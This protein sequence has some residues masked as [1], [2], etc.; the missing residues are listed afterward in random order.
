MREFPVIDISH[1]PKRYQR[2]NLIEAGTA[3]SLQEQ[4]ESP[5]DVTYV[6][7]SVTIERAIHYYEANSTG[8]LANLYSATAKWLRSYLAVSNSAVRKAVEESEECTNETTE[9]SET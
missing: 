2:D 9:G 5:V 4:E 6:P 1:K 3:T 7:R 8:E